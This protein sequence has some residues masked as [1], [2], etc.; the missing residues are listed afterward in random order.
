MT[1]V[2]NAGSRRADSNYSNSGKVCKTSDYVL[3][4][5]RIVNMYA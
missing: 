4:V 5:G 2:S 1:V 3:N